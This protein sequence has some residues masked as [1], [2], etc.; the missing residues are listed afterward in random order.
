MLANSGVEINVQFGLS[1]QSRDRFTGAA[2]LEIRPNYFLRCLLFTLKEFSSK[3]HVQF[4]SFSISKG[5]Y[6]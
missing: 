5:F 3:F 4:Q 1:F 6:D 2:G